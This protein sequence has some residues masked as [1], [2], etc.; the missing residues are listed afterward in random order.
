MKVLYF[1]GLGGASGDMILAALASLGVD[2]DSVEQA[3]SRLAG[4]PIR[5]RVEPASSHALH[6]VRVHVEAPEDSPSTRHRSLAD[7]LTLIG[8][9]DLPPGV[10]AQS[11]RVFMRLAEA[12]A[13]V[14]NTTPDAIHFH[15]V[16]ALD[17]IADI[18]GCCLGLDRLAVDDVAVAPLPIG[19]GTVECAH[20]IYPTP[21]PATAWL[22]RDS[23]VVQTDEPFEL[24][25]PTGAAL[26]TTWRSLA[27]VPPGSRLVQIGYGFGHRTLNGRPN[28]LR[29]ML[30]EPPVES[31]G[32]SCLVLECHVDDTTP[33]LIGQFTEKALAAGA[34][35]VYT[36]GVQMKKQRPGTLVTILCRL[37]DR[38]AVL[39]LLFRETTTFGVRESVSQRTT[40]K[41]RMETVET[42]FGPVRVKVG[43]WRGDDVTV[44]PEMDDCIRLASEAGVSTRSV[45]EAALRPVDH[46]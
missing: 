1:Q 46:G 37:D 11:E 8:N 40:L 3:V 16:G 18:V 20:G 45:Y 14:H 29:A 42:P 34:L 38:E 4:T 19:C 21:A 44:A 36:T 10:Q 9:G 30:F 15:E 17:S 2:L 7:I 5:L 24:V 31:E 6:G 28:V 26:L 23:A 35:D 25:T 39:D 43:T 33:E 41:R 32:D 27:L 22:L 13:D 12:E